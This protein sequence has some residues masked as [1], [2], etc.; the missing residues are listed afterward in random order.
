MDVA[1]LDRC[2]SRPVFLP[3]GDRLPT[4]QWIWTDG[5]GCGFERA[6]RWV[7]YHYGNWTREDL[8]AGVGAVFFLVAGAGP[9]VLR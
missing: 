4:V 6:V 3:I 2:G 9:M 1:G 8:S 7:V 5:D